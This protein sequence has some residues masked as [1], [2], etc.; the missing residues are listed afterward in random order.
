MHYAYKNLTGPNTAIDVLKFA[1]NILVL[2]NHTLVGIE[3]G[4]AV[5]SGTICFKFIEVNF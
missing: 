5:I 3:V 4:I 1:K 2:E